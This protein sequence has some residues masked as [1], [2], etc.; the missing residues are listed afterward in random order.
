MNVPL[1]AAGCLAVL[2][3]AVHGFGGEILVVRKLSPRVLPPTRFGGPRMTKAMIHV[4]WHITTVAFLGVGCALL[5]SAS[6]VSGDAAHAIG[7]VAAAV[8]TGF[9][10]VGIGL[11]IAYS[12]RSLLAHPGPVVF[13][14]TAALAWWG[15]L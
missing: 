13:A 8:F 11:G 12:P 10:I 6:V 3:A 5:A 9:A 4:T 2:A 1:L 7:V 15:A 14:V